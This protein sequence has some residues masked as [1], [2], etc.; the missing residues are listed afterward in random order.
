MAS[1]INIV[2]P[3]DEEMAQEGL[4]QIN[5]NNGRDF[6]RGKEDGTENFRIDCNGHRVSTTGVTRHVV[7]MTLGD[8]IADSDALIYPIFKPF[9]TK[10]GATKVKIEVESVQIGV[11]T[12]LAAS[13][14]AYETI[15]L[16]DGLGNTVASGTTAAGLTAGEL[17]TLG[18][19]SSTYG[20][21]DPDDSKWLHLHFAKTGVGGAMSGFHIQVILIVSADG[22]VSSDTDEDD[23]VI[24]CINHDEATAIILLDDTH[25]NLLNLKK[26]GL[27]V[28]RVDI[29]GVIHT[30]S[31]D[32]YEYATI[33]LGTIDVSEDDAKVCSILKPEN[34]II[35]RG[36]AIGVN[37]A[38]ALSGV[39]DYET[40]LVLND[41]VTIGSFTTSGP[42]GSGLP[43]TAGGM[44]WLNIADSPNA[45]LASTDT[46]KLSFTKAG[47]GGT[48]LAG[49]TVQVVYT[50]EK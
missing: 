15:S 8:I 22:N 27:S 1:K 44:S 16:K 6:L 32:K 21:I 10:D 24:R 35:I 14:T 12:T 20:E 28:F 42:A 7:L 50:R 29:D 2:D 41:T 49:L 43:L 3:P 17:T 33:N 26:D 13:A 9:E 30:T 37:T 18:S 47:T 34:D 45:K 5:V 46:L 36:I 40:I 23:A 31:N 19:V 38:V 4:L 39:T 25:R 11:D 48:D